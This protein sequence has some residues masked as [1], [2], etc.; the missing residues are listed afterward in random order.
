[1]R[2]LWEEFVDACTIENVVWALIFVVIWALMP[3]DN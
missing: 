2:R 3:G 1:M